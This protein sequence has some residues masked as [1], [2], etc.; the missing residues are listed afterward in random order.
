MPNLKAVRD[1]ILLVHVDRLIYNDEF[2]LLYDINQTKN[3][4]LQYYNYEK[5]N[6]DLLNEDECQSEFRFQKRDIYRLCDTL[7]I[8][9]ESRCYNVVV[10]EK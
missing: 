1:T 10:A 5:F 2:L 6:L 7:Q 4:D 3:L 9:E 8:S